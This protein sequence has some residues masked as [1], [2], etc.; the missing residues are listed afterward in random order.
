M[1][2]LN[3]TTFYITAESVTGSSDKVDFSLYPDDG[4]WIT[5]I[6]WTFKDWGYVIGFCTPKDFSLT[7]P[8]TPP[9]GVKKTWEVAFTPEDVNIKCNT[10]EVLHLIFND[11][12]GHNDQCSNWVKGKIA[13]RVQFSMEDTAAKMLRTE[14][15]CK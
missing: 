4:Q 1:Y 14:I 13:T 15:V 12:L 9:T 7:F 8:V 10:L 11:T 2:P 6:K 5:S 3:S